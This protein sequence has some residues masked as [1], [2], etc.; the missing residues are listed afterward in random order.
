MRCNGFFPQNHRYLWNHTQSFKTWTNLLLTFF[1][2]HIA[3]NLHTEARGARY[4]SYLQKYGYD[5]AARS[6]LYIHGSGYTRAAQSLPACT[7][8][9]FSHRGDLKKTA[10]LSS[11]ANCSALTTG[12]TTPCIHES[13]KH[14]YDCDQQSRNVTLAN[15]LYCVLKNSV[16]FPA[17]P[18]NG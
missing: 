18:R 10:I 4:L 9:E 1:K 5:R 11:C 6:R 16:S 12:R 13:C 3:E 7:V 15:T 8:S 17:K 2:S 14:S